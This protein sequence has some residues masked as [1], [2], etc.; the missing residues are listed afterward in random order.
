MIEGELID[1]IKKIKNMKCENQNIEL[2][3][4]KVDCPKRLYDTLSAFSTV[5]Y[6]GKIVVCAEIPGIDITER[7]CYYG[8]V[9]KVKGSYIRVG[10]SEYL[11]HDRKFLRCWEFLQLPIRQNNILNRW[12][13]QEY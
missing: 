9:G 1:L 11:V 7:P 6:E 5:L 4:A 8:G 3:A 12:L 2:K 10:D 13:N